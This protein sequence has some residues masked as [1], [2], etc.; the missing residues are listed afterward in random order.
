MTHARF[1]L[2]A[3]ML[4]LIELASA[5]C[6]NVVIDQAGNVWSLN[7]WKPDFDI[8]VCCNPGGD[9]AVI[10]VGLAAPPALQK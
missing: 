4:A 9:A 3:A 8:D 2:S 6:A 1:V 7:N 5:L 10:F